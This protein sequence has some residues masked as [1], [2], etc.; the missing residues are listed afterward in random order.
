[1]DIKLKQKGL[2]QLAGTDGEAALSALN[3]EL[4]KIETILNKETRFDLLE[5]QLSLLREIAFRVPEAA[6]KVAQS[7][8]E[9]LD[10]LTLTYETSE[11]ASEEQQKKYNNKSSLI[12]KVLETVERIRYFQPEQSL[13]IFLSYASSNEGDEVRKK[14]A[15]GLKSLAGFNLDVFKK[16]GT[17]PQDIIIKKIGSLD[18]VNRKRFFGSIV[19]LCYEMLSPTMEGSY[20][21][22]K[23]VVLKTGAVPASNPIDEARSNTLKILTDLYSSASSVSQKKAIISALQQA[24]R[25][26]SNVNYGDDLLKMIF[27]NTATILEF[28]K[29]LIPHEDLSIIQKIEHDAFWLAKHR[30]KDNEI[31]K[32]ALSIKERIDAHAEYR[33]FKNLIGFE[34]IFQA[35]DSEDDE[36]FDAT[37][38][39]R[40]EKSKEYAG[41]IDEKSYEEWKRRI[42]LY[43]QIKSDDLATFPYFG[44]FLEFFGAASPM[45][46]LRLLNEEAETLRQF[47]IAILIGIWSTPK[48]DAARE[49]IQD[50]INQRLHLFFIARFF[51]F[52]PTVDEGLLKQLLGIAIATDDKDILMEMV[53]IAAKSYNEEHEHLIDELFFPALAHLTKLKESRWVFNF[54]YREERKNLL[55]AM[56]DKGHQMLLDNLIYLKKI[57][58]HAEE[59]LYQ[60]A[61]KSPEL[62]IKFFG[63]RLTLKDANED[64]DY[65]AI[66]FNF[67]KLS[68]ALSPIPDKA[69]EIVSSW[70]QNYGSFIYEGANLLKIIFPDF[71]EAFAKAL[72]SIIQPENERNL[73]VVMAVLR[74]YEGQIATHPVCK[75]LVKVLPEDSKYLAEIRVALES[76]GVVGGEFGFADAYKR[77]KVEMASWLNDPDKKVKKF[78]EHYIA[79]LDKDIVAEQRRAEE[80]IALGKF[81]W[82]EGE[83]PDEAS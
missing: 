65:D 76:T 77:K 13:D 64:A 12:K 67:Y 46:A 35:W 54:W 23:S 41:N 60:I 8:L 62:V 58:Y 33:I 82:G 61:K 9:R 44:K 80:R 72:I 78:A 6:I 40:E 55:A 29:Q 63:K 83:E 36:N 48:K 21:N 38:K 69:V 5:G 79:N 37:K 15:Q 71:S 27:S 10:N 18:E 74:N 30:G 2:R 11:W 45:L 16:I 22:Y 34:G 59:I 26:P 31:L 73:M 70:Y 49:L 20:W 52:N 66:P 47:V 17:A 57:D 51:E 68:P 7:F 19:T 14:A 25:T 56:N 4:N 1:M 39:I 53:I 50:W 3:K 42:I 81:E 32:V 75:A 28:Y 24:T 43:S